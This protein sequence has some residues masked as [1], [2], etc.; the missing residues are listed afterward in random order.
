MLRVTRQAGSLSRWILLSS[1]LFLEAKRVRVGLTLSATKSKLLL[2]LRYA[3]YNPYVDFTG[4]H[5]RPRRSDACHVLFHTIAHGAYGVI[6]A[7]DM[8]VFCVIPSASDHLLIPCLVGS[9]CARHHPQR[10]MRQHFAG[11][12]PRSPRIYLLVG[13]RREER[14]VLG[15]NVAPR[16]S[17]FS[18]SDQG[19]SP[20]RQAYLTPPSAV[21]PG[22]YSNCQPSAIVK[23]G[24]SER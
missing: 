3:R 14:L 7:A 13:Y 11:T 15:P 6:P 19:H 8:N 22:L 17:V 5:L 23:V 16:R 24:S 4:D 18:A 12:D 21:H 2:S 9:Y 10:L 20:F 1:T